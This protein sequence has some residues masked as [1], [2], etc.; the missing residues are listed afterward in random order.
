MLVLG[1]ADEVEAKASLNPFVGNQLYELA[2]LAVKL[3]ADPPGKQIDDALAD[4]FTFGNE[5]TVN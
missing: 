5:L 1:E 2:P 3:I 4:I